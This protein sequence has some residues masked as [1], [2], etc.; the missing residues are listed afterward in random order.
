MM[1]EICTPEFVS[2]PY[3]FSQRHL[4]TTAEFG[5]EAARRGCDLDAGQLEAF[6]RGG[7]LV[8]LLQLNGIPQPIGRIDAQGHHQLL[9]A[10]RDGALQDPRLAGYAPWG[11][12]RHRT[13]RLPL[14]TR[15]FLYS[16]WQLLAVP[17]LQRV[18]DS[19]R[20]RPRRGLPRRT[21]YLR[22]PGE[23]VTS[24]PLL[25]LL[26]RLEPVYLTGIRLRVHGGL[27]PKGLDEWHREYVNFQ[28]DFDPVAAMR[29]LGVTPSEVQDMAEGLITQT[30]FFDPLRQWLPLVRNMNPDKWEDLSG[31]ALS[32]IDSRVAAE[33][34]L[35]FY[36]DLAHANAAEPLPE[37]P[38]MESH[39]L[40]ERIK[41]QAEELDPQLTNFGLS[42]VP[43]VLVVLEGPS[44]LIL[45]RL[46][47]QLMGIRVVRNFI[48]L[49][50]S[51]GADVEL[52]LLAGFAS[53]PDPGRV[54]EDHVVLRRPTTRLLRVV[55]EEGKSSSAAGRAAV[56]RVLV[57]R[58]RAGLRYRGGP[59][60]HP[61]DLEK[62]VEVYSWGPL[63][64]EFA[65]FTDRELATAISRL[66]R[67]ATSVTPAQLAVARKA[68]MPG[69]ALKNLLK[70][71]PKIEKT[72]LA[73]AL[74]P[75]L[76]R[77]IERA[78]VKNQIESV[79]MAAL[80]L[81][82]V[83]MALEW[84]RHSLAMRRL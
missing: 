80:V 59:V 50:E 17:Q 7:V 54:L 73:E 40:H 10:A 76:Q 83:D 79:A 33:V 13:G 29:D 43:S 46:T 57:E 12:F 81:K 69:R 31:P 2:W 47:M 14:Y 63:P 42:P 78:R 84:P 77:R 60:L 36:E 23:E 19:L 5:R 56:K 6:H 11:R 62:L 68:T 20:P 32:A 22:N 53:E 71:P 26:T 21:Y 15:Y 38:S 45:M 35:Q 55:D 25:A 28:R 66:R 1:R 24:L 34:L 75:A 74:W 27:H 37:I 18:Q 64:M 72:D 30:W 67:P 8:P 44:D 9:T 61:D 49:V 70:G 52:T 41:R 48:E 58:I 3:A 65:N 39:P 51:G 4:L 82:A 16:W